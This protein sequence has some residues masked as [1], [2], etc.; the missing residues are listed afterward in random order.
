MVSF[1]MEHFGAT[2]NSFDWCVTCHC[3]VVIYT[4]KKNHSVLDVSESRDTDDEHDE[5]TVSS[6]LGAYDGSTSLSSSGHSV[7]WRWRG[8]CDVGGRLSLGVRFLEARF[9]GGF[10][11]Y[12]QKKI[13]G[14]LQFFDMD[15]TVRFF[16]LVLFI[17]IHH[18]PGCDNHDRRGAK[19]NDFRQ[20]HLE[21]K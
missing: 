17:C 1:S 9:S 16:F 2:S 5:T 6:S 18:G 15:G 14:F 21:F 4:K 3:V 12:I 7:R 13:Q 19:E 8:V 20:F 10:I 11:R